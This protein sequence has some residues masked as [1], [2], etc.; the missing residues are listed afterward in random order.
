MTKRF[1]KSPTLSVVCRPV[2]SLGVSQW[3]FTIKCDRFPQP[4]LAKVTRIGCRAR[5]VRLYVLLRYS[6]ENFGAASTGLATSKLKAVAMSKLIP[7]LIY[8]APILP[9]HTNQ[10]SGIDHVI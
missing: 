10:W 3:Q 5:Y 2:I 8:T 6:T 9:L 1:Q 7:E 4:I